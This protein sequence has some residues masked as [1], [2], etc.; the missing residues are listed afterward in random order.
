MLIKYGTYMRLQIALNDTKKRTNF[1]QVKYFPCDSVKES[2]AARLSTLHNLLKT[3]RKKYKET[4]LHSALAKYLKRR[5]RERLPCRRNTTAT[6][7]QD[8][9]KL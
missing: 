6:L 1:M 4:Y 5:Q 2:F 9:K 3:N 7:L 8:E